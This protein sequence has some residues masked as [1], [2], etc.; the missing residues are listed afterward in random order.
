FSTLVVPPLNEVA[1]TRTVP[2][3]L[4][5]VAEPDEVAGTSRPVPVGL[6]RGPRNASTSGAS[7]AFMRRP[8]P[9]RPARPPR[10][11]VAVGPWLAVA[12]TSSPPATTVAPAPT[13]AHVATP[14]LL[15]PWA[16]ITCA[17]TVRSL[18][19]AAWPETLSAVAA[20]PVSA[21][22]R[23]NTDVLPASRSA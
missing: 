3:T 11:P 18:A 20:G 13:Y 19:E 7:C 15:S 6:A 4:I 9:L 5:V 8:D 16:G 2:G 17:V 14:S 12:S 22:A 1:F 21:S 10:A 23:T